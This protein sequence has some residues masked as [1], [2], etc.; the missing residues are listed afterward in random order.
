[1]VQHLQLNRVFHLPPEKEL[2][3]KEKFEEREVTVAQRMA[4][5]S[6]RLIWHNLESVLSKLGGRVRYSCLDVTG[7]IESYISKKRQ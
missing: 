4:T 6:P 1:M 7:S 5:E 3:P 2:K